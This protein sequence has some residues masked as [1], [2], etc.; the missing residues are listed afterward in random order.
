[1]RLFWEV[2]KLSLQRQ[3]TYR[4]ATIAGLL[5]NFF[6]G[7]LRAALLVAL[8]GDRSEVAGIT[9]QGAVTY[10]G[11]TQASIG[12]L[13]LFSWYELAN[14]VY[15]GQIASDLLKPMGY[16]RFWL[17]QD[18]G[19]ASAQLAL[20]GFPLIAAY[21][22]FFGITT[23]KGVVQWMAL[24]CV[25]ALA[26]LVSFSWRFLVNLAAFWSPN[27]VGIGRFFFLSSYFMSGFV[28][29]LRFFPS[30]FVS[31]CYLTPFPHVVNAVVETHL[32]V[33][34]ESELVGTLLGQLVWAA[35]LILLGQIVLRAGIRRLVILGG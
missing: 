21:A 5:T 7:L 10:T 2:W 12:F 15:T 29:P 26:W 30:W 18:L 1:M 31:L 33:L 16:Y 35:L 13:S 24:A 19:R 14:T 32:G 25:M 28:I 20:R 6:F 22:I 3:M 27:A 11:L 34:S 17:A 4:A 9:V 8:Y 23:P